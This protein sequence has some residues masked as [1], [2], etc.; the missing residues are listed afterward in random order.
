MKIANTPNTAPAAT[1]IIPLSRL[2]A[3]RPTSALASSI[4]SR[5]RLLIRSETSVT[6]LHEV[7]WLTVVSGQGA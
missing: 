2:M 4:S 1:A 5:I 7:L 6:V 3:L